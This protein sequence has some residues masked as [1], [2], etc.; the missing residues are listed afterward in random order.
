MSSFFSY[1]IANQALQ[2]FQTAL[3][4]TGNNV[5]NVNTEGYTRQ[6]VDLTQ[7]LGIER[8][9]VNPYQ[10]GSGVS[11]A[12]VS[13]IR[14]S[15]LDVSMW[16]AQSDMGKYQT[17]STNMQAIQS[18]FPEPGDN[19]IAASMS[20]FFNAWSALASGPSAANKLAVQQAGS[21]LAQKI[22]GTY[23]QLQQLSGS[24]QSQLNDAFDQ[25]DQLTKDISNLNTKITA[26]TAAGGQPNSLIDQRNLDIKKLSALVDVQTYTDKGGA[27]TVYTNQ[28]NLV[29]AGGATPIPRTADAVNLTLTN[30]AQSTSIRSGQLAGLLQSLGNVQS[31]SSQLDALANNLRSQVNAIHQTGKNSSGGTDVLFFNNSVPQTGAVDLDLSSSVKAD[32]N[33]IV[34]GVSGNAGDGGLALSISRL[35]NTA[36][37]S[38]NSLS[39]KDYYQGLVG[40]IGSAAQHFTN[41]QDTQGALVQQIDAQRQSVS[42]VNVDEEMSNMLRYQRSYE[43]AAKALSVFDQTTNDV[44]GL[45]K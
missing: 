1:D 35:A 27:V 2:A 42:G 13:Q 19:G 5:T 18:M 39:F 10:L 14:D 24:L 28:L 45:I 17:L 36:I 12:A 37:S 7:S 29:D 3:D 31:Y 11:V 25:V 30:G 22:R 20:K 41:A 6:S 26:Q 32:P 21:D 43:A 38:L 4:V 34:V 15:L 16:N 33:A 40:T 9:G 8:Y 44:I 23:A